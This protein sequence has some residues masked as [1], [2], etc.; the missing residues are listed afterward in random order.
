MAK[1]TTMAGPTQGGDGFGFGRGGG[2]YRRRLERDLGIAAGPS[3]DG[4]ARAALG[5]VTTRDRTV[6][7]RRPL[8]PAAVLLAV[9]LLAAGCASGAKG[10]PAPLGSAQLVD[11]TAGQ[12]AGDLNALKGRVVVVNFW[13]SWCA[14]CRA[15]MPAL[16]RASRALAAK[17][18]TFVGVDA[19]DQ[20]PEAAKALAQAGVTYPTVYDRKGIYGGIASQWSVGQ[21]PQTW[22]VDRQGR[23]VVKIARQ[24]RP[25]ELA[26]TVER[27]LA[28]P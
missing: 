10:A 11:R 26:A 28:A 24:V 9:S 12:F 21:L 2:W 5:G 22:F 23:R 15:E 25:E 27:L 13:A 4:R 14:P 1:L 16:Q 20:R 8:L 3:L 7:A 17:P 18:V 6:P 19:S